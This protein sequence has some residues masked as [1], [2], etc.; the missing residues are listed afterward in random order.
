M[1]DLALK[2]SEDHPLEKLVQ[3]AEESDRHVSLRVFWV[4]SG[5]QQCDHVCFPPY[6]WNLLLFKAVIN[7][8]QEPKPCGWSEVFDYFMMDVIQARR[9]AVC[10]ER[11]GISKVSDGEWR[12]D[13]FMAVGFQYR[14]FMAYLVVLVRLP[15]QQ[16]VV[17]NRVRCYFQ[18]S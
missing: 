3:R 2:A 11:Y 10:E 4:F 6:V 17:G 1:L 12:Q 18:R 9:L 13:R 8:V 14:L 5:L 16:E 15:V 7:H